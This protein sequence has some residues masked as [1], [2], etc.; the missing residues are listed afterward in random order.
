MTKQKSTIALI[1]SLCIA[2]CNA[3]A[4]VPMEFKV[5][6]SFEITEK[7][8]EEITNAI[9]EKLLEVDFSHPAGSPADM[10]DPEECKEAYARWL[11]RQFAI[12]YVPKKVVGPDDYAQSSS[13][14]KKKECKA[15]DFAIK[16]KVSSDKVMEQQRRDIVLFNMEDTKEKIDKKK[17]LKAFIDPEKG[18]MELTHITL[19]VEKNRLNVASPSYKIYASNRVLTEDDVKK[20]PEQRFVEDGTFRLFAN[21]VPIPAKYTGESR[22]DPIKDKELYKKA[23]VPLLS[24]TG[25]F[26]GYPNFAQFEPETKEL[27]GQT[28]FI[29]PKGSLKAEIYL[30]F[31]FIASLKDAVCTYNDLIDQIKKIEQDRESEE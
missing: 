5:K 2:L 7:D 11:N 17:C 16:Y 6:K 15:I 30:M 13:N 26:V 12:G 22:V 1:A 28:Y 24:L 18:K 31:N 19:K 27:G 10:I 9:K 20:T 23:I 8:L 25:S 14:P 21:S 4:K 3:C 29:V